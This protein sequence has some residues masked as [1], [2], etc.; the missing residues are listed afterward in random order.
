VK[1][2]NLHTNDLFR[3]DYGDRDWNWYRDLMSTCIRY[4]M[5][6]KWLDLGA[7]LGLFVECANRFGINC[8]GLEGSDYGIEI[9]RIRF[10]NI[11]MRKHFLEDELPF[12]NDSIST[13]MCYQVIEHLTSQTVTFLFKESYRILKEGGVLFVYSPSKYNRKERL[14]ETHINLYTNNK[15]IKK[16]TNSGFEIHEKNINSPNLFLG[17]SRISVYLMR[18]VYKLFP[19]SYLSATAN[20]IAIKP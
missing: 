5:P 9:S 6:G 2:T 11:D 17:T 16:L 18:V 15:L 13:I 7:G 10:P 1:G 14:K 20:C 4:G 19:F 8:I 12:E 3:I